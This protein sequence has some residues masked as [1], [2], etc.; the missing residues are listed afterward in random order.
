MIPFR[1]NHNIIYCDEKDTEC[2]GYPVTLEK[3]QSFPTLKIGFEI[4]LKYK[5]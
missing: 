4:Y 3:R 5:F 1:Y 2:C